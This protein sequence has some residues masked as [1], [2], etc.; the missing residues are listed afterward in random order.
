[1]PGSETVSCA[2]HIPKSGVEKGHQL[3]SPSF[4]S[5]RRVPTWRS[6]RRTPS[7]TLL[8]APDSSLSAALPEETVRLGAPVLGG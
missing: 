8:Y 6:S 2:S 3:C 7:R 4:G 1:M 5:L